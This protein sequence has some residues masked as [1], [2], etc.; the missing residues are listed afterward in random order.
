MARLELRR[1]LNLV[2]ARQVRPAVD[3]IAGSVRNEAQR[4]APAAKVWISERD[5]RVRPSH[6]HADGQTIPENLRY[7]LRRMTYVRK[8][9]DP[10]TRKALNPAG[11][12]KEA[13]GFDLAREPR[14]PA[15]PDEQKKMCRCHSFPLP[16]A[17][18]R[19]IFAQPAQVH[20]TRVTAR[21]E[22]TFNRIAE[23]EFGNEHDA[24]TRFMGRAADAVAR[25][26]R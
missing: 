21:V 15:L 16:D 13:A 22:V 25:R 20:G 26:L 24:G 2:A 6:V 1:D 18:S 8:G 9:R 11:G 5:A 7:R 10:R 19:R 12:W 23:A 17:I 14:D 3:R 4:R